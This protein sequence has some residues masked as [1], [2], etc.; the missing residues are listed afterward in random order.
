MKN[1]TN[2]LD[3]AYIDFLAEAG[4]A[5]AKARPLAGDASTRCYLRLHKNGQPAVLMI[6]PPG[7]ESAAC[8]PSASPEERLS[9]GY[10]ASA[11]LAGPNLN[12]FIAIARA[13]RGA[14]L[15][16]PDIYA[17]DPD[18]G[19]ALIEDLGDDL[20]ARVV[21]SVDEKQIYIAAIDVLIAMRKT[22]PSR[23][24][25]G[26]Y[27]MLDYDATALLTETELLTQWYWPL[28]NNAEA[29]NDLTTEY[30]EI[31]RDLTETLSPP[32]SFVLRDYHAENLLWM[33]ERSSVQTV[34]LI[35]FQDGLYGAAAY[36]IVSLLEDARRDVAP[37]LAAAMID[38]YCK[39]AKTIGGFDHD[40]FLNDYAI[41]A[42]QRNA[43]ILGIF[44]RLAKRDLKPRYLDLLPRV[45]AHF[46]G[47]LQR[48][49][50][51][52]LRQFFT[53]H[54]PELAP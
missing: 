6:A 14:G 25:G 18:R 26:D 41:L 11:R 45:E 36:D 1:D 23:P 35:D 54:I 10:N 27:S 46:R 8:P 3:P 15:S 39:D 43:K 22:P 30:N 7:E 29:H 9:L 33:P 31:F 44:A 51:E 52:R 13:L 40:A 19:L 12:A 2:S 24:S 4:W 32:H 49:G 21:G 34:G 38:H 28:K 37:E 16:A 42:A 5:N 48:P 20:F 17:A 47:D 53:T 50:L